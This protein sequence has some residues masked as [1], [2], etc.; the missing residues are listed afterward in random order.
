V[1]VIVET[2]DFRGDH[3]ADRE[4][5]VTVPDDAPVSTLR[6]LAKRH[7]LYCGTDATLRIVP[8]APP[9]RVEK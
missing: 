2:D 7:T 8:E 5:T 6:E 3:S 9:E 4:L 1:I